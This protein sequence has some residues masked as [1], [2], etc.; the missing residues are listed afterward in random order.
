MVYEP[1]QYLELPIIS[2]DSFQAIG[3]SG[4][5]VGSVHRAVSG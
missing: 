5:R 2:S 1:D 3:T 4:F